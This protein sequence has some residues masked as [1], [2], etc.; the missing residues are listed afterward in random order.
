[1]SPVKE[2]ALSGLNGCDIF[3]V[4]IRIIKTILLWIQDYMNSE[5]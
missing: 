1:M 5:G 4:H 3:F 2:N